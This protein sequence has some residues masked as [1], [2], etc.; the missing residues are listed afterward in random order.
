MHFSTCRKI[1]LF[2]IS[3]YFKHLEVKKNDKINI[4]RNLFVLLENSGLS[5]KAADDIF[6]LTQGSFSK[7]VN[8]RHYPR[9]ETLVEIADYFKVSLENLILGQIGY[10]H[11]SELGDHLRG[12]HKVNDAI[13]KRKAKEVVQQGLDKD[14]LI[15]VL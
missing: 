15:Q 7:Y 14:H 1:T 4:S 11:N 9:I 6:G 3:L 12:L 2:L 8:N 5:K 13:E 10:E